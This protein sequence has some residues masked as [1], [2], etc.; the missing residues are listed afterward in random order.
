MLKKIIIANQPLY[1]V[2][3]I[4]MKRQKKKNKIILLQTTGI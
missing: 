2:G 4:H 1:N 3:K